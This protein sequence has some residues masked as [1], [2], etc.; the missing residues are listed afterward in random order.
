METPKFLGVQKNT[1][2]ELGSVCM[3][4]SPPP[5][6]FDPFCMAFITHCRSHDG[7][8]T[9]APNET[10]YTTLNWGE[11]VLGGAIRNLNFLSIIVGR[12][13]EREYG[14]FD[15]ARFPFFKV[16]KPPMQR[17]EYPMFIFSN[18]SKPT[19]DSVDGATPHHS[20]VPSALGSFSWEINP[21]DFMDRS[22]VERRDRKEHNHKHYHRKHKKK[23]EKTSQDSVKKD[24]DDYIVVE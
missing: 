20:E 14:V 16:L 17:S 23:R 12:V 2:L 6:N 11:G 3:C 24:I 4:L 21:R 1:P 19:I 5:F 8:V 18:G 13:Y 9:S 10:K 22:V 15:I 7:S